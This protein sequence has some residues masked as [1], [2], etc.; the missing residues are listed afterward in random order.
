MSFSFHSIS[1]AT[2][3]RLEI[4]LDCKP[5]ITLRRLTMYSSY[6]LPAAVCGPLAA[7]PPSQSSSPSSSSEPKD[8]LLGGSS[9]NSSS[10]SSSTSSTP[11]PSSSSAASSSVPVYTEVW[12]EELMIPWEFESDGER[13]TSVDIL[14]KCFNTLI[15]DFEYNVSTPSGFILIVIKLLWYPFFSRLSKY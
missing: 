5:E 12:P 4:G 9:S 6:Y 13:N 15:S 14:T 1:T 8:N 11:A 10:S 3:A 2:D 7:P